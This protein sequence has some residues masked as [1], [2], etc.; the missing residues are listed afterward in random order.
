MNPLPDL[1]CRVP[2][3]PSRSPV[4]TGPCW[5]LLGPAV[6]MP[7]WWLCGIV[8]GAEAVVGPCLMSALDTWWVGAA[9]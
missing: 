1:V 7:R 4:P 5:W 8:P 9:G 2:S 6:V 3:A